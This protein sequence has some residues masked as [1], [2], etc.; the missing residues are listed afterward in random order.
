M[1]ARPASLHK[2]TIGVYHN[3]RAKQYR[4]QFSTYEMELQVSHRVCTEVQEASILWRETDRN[5]GDTEETVPM[6]RC[7]SDRGRG[8]PGSHTHVGE[9]TAQNERCGI[10]GVPEREEQPDD[11]PKMGED[12][13]CIP[14]PRILV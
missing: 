2:N 3:P 7:G 4:K 12:E 13:I 10:Y 8:M 14:Q 1:R 5:T 9:H 11:F 6:E